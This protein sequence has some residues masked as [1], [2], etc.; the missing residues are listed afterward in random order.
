MTGLFGGAF[1]PPH[2]GHVALA[3]AAVERF[4]LERLVVFPTGVAPHKD[5]RTPGEVRLRLARAAFADVPGAEVSDWE[6]RRGVPSYTLETTRWAGERWGELIFLV[7]ADQFAAFETW[8]RPEEVLEL[9][10]LGVATRPGYDRTRLEEL[11]GRLRD[12]SRVE[13]FE[14]E[15]V[16]VSS[17]ELRERVARGGSLDGLVPPDVARLIADLGLYRAE[18]SAEAAGT[19]GET[20]RG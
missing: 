8:Y 19:L 13:F 10:R 14:I 11:R 4:A 12:P 1:D 20:G 9:A 7:G 17:T 3:R 15:P 2:N 5:V 16:A 6:L 18:S